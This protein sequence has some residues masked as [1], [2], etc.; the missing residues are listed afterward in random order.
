[1]FSKSSFSASTATL[2]S[3]TSTSS[4]STL[5]KPSAGTTKQKDYFAA[6]GALQTSYGFGG[7]APAL[8]ATSKSTKA[9]KAKSA[10]TQATAAMPAAKGSQKDYEAAYGALSASY[11]FG[12]AAPA[13]PSKASWM[14]KK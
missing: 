10:K 2:S 13:I 4:T 7:A 11:G 12:G 6:L 14:S 3:V 5:V 1:M 8:H 9:S